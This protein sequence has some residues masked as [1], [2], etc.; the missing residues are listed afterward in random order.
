MVFVVLNPSA[1]RISNSSLLFLHKHHLLNVAVSRARD[2]LFLVYPDQNTDGIDNL[3][4]VH[5]THAGS[6]ET[7]I[8]T[9][10]GWP[11]SPLTVEA[12]VLEM[13]LFSESH[14]IQQN[15]FTHQHQLVNV[16]AKPQH[17]YLVKE[18]TTAIDV[19]FQH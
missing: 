7:L 11:L 1:S 2:Y 17:K 13:R 10:L 8:E 9:Q 19:Q 4:K 5:R 14:H 3:H 16:Y 12:S 18:S 15:I 6:L